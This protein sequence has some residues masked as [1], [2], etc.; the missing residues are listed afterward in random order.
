MT[1]PGAWWL[2]CSPTVTTSWRWLWSMGEVMGLEVKPRNSPPRKEVGLTCSSSRWVW[3]RVVPPGA[4]PAWFGTDS[5]GDFSKWMTITKMTHPH[6]TYL[7]R[8]LCSVP[9]AF[10]IQAMR[11]TPA[12]PLRRSH[13]CTWPCRRPAY[14]HPRPARASPIASRNTPGKSVYVY[15]V[16][17][18]VSPPS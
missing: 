3:T 15:R 11:L 17:P 12:R 16:L 8:D 6:G 13:M 2:A 5:Q 7:S 1:V 4:A 9:M 10:Q 18:S 14:H